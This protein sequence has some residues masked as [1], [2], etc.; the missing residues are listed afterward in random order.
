LSHTRDASFDVIML[1]TVHQAVDVRIFH[2]EAKTLAQA[3]LAVCIIG[4]HPKSEYLDGVWV[5]A[6][7]TPTSRLDRLLL[8]ATLLKHAQRFRGKVYI[9]HDLELFAVGLAL[10]L[11]GR[12]VIYDCH[13]N[14]PMTMLQK[15]W[16]PFPFRLALVPIVAVIELLGSRLLTGVLVVNETLLNRFPRKQT[17]VVRNLPTAATLDTLGEAPPLHSRAKVVIYAGGLTR[18]RGIG[19]L[20]QAF[21]GINSGAELWL[22]G[23]FSEPLF[24]QEILSSLPPNVK[25][26]GRKEYSEVLQLYRCAKVGVVLHHPTWSHRNAMPIKLF[27]YLGAGLPVIASDMP[28]FSLMLQGCGVQVD[29]KDVTQIRATIE[30]VLADEAALAEM[31]K[32]ARERVVNSFCWESEGRRLVDFCNHA[33]GAS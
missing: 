7:P 12:K 13:E 22:V 25:W 4:Q 30:K 6:L 15:S 1:T 26:F 32:V 5:E 31:S 29:P 8:G 27:E 21:Q 16:I 2:R 24:G 9:F 28:E 3:G 14:T 33:V 19:E 10:R 18:I 11:I 17:I 20:V 23:E